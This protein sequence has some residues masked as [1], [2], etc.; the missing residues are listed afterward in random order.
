[1]GK[2]GD[3][4]AGGLQLPSL[5]FSNDH[6]GACLQYRHTLLIGIVGL[7]RDD[8][9]RACL[10]LARFRIGDRHYACQDIA[11]IDGRKVLILFFAMQNTHNVNAC[12]DQLSNHLAVAPESESSRRG[13]I[14]RHIGISGGLRGFFALVNRVVITDGLREF[15][16][17]A[18]LDLDGERGEALADL[19][20]V[21]HELLLND[22]SL[23]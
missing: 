5:L 1:M 9:H 20:F 4:G 14:N 15:A 17:F 19:A 18:A 13:W 22:W 23:L 11:R 21:E 3:E 16:D 8:F 2:G 12:A 6:D 10:T 7:R